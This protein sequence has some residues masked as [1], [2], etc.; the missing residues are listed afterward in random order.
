MRYV[1]CNREVLLN[2]LKKHM[3]I[4]HGGMIQFDQELRHYLYSLKAPINKKYFVCLQCHRPF[5]NNREYFLHKF[6][7][8]NRSDYAPAP[9]PQQQVGGGGGAAA[10][11]D[12]DVELL[13]HSQVKAWKVMHYVIKAAE[14][15][16]DWENYVANAGDKFKKKIASFI[17]AENANQLTLQVKCLFF[18]CVVC[19]CV[20]LHSKI[21]L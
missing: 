19:V 8:H 20:W 12:D 16:I 18:Y 13:Q 4:N 15:R 21:I 2:K 7:V 3:A 9:P 1:I 17:R 14:G 10:T 6:L 11:D 5:D